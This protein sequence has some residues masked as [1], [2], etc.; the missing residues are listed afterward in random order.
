MSLIKC[1]ECGKEISDK[2][3]VCI[4]CGCP[5]SQKEDKYKII[6][7]SDS[8]KIETIKVLMDV[9]S[10]S[11]AEAK[12]ETENTPKVLF[13]NLKLSEANEILEKFKT[14]NA[15]ILLTLQNDEN[16]SKEITSTTENKNGENVSQ[17]ATTQANPSPNQKNKGCGIAVAIAI[18]IFIILALIGGAEEN[19]NDGKCDICG[20]PAIKVSGNAELCLDHIV[21]ANNEYYKD[22]DNYGG[23]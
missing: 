5:I 11:L 21:K 17:S 1:S 19:H 15:D 14:V 4:N 8:N 9:K 22:N 20:K 16:K 18:V 2:A 7:K 12:A 10:I 6:L 23:F 13:N 3:S